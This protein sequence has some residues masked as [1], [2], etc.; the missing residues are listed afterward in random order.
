LFSANNDHHSSNNNNEY[1]E[2]VTTCT[3]VYPFNLYSDKDIK[4]G[5]VSFLLPQPDEE[6]EIYDTSSTN[7][8]Y[9]LHNTLNV[10]DTIALRPSSNGS[11]L[12]IKQSQQQQQLVENT[13]TTSTYNT[14]KGMYKD[15][16][17][18]YW[19]YRDCSCIGSNNGCIIR[20]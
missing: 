2:I 20:N 17:Y 5:I 9:N 10:G 11:K 7:I 3:D 1:N 19:C 18:C 4:K 6:V 16:I 13:T 14:I 8:K 15:C 12:L